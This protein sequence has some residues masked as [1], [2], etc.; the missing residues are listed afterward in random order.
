MNSLT[1]P[2]IADMLRPSAETIARELLPNGKR[3]GREWHCTGSNSPVGE[4]VGVVLSGAK[5]GTCCFF[6]SNRGG[7]LIELAQTVLGLDKRGAV[8][9]AKQFLGLP[10]DDRPIDPKEVERRRAAA[11]KQ[12]KQRERQEAR[13]NYRKIKSAWEIWDEAQ[14]LKLAYAY[15]KSRGID[16][17]HADGEI[18]GHPDLPHPQGSFPALVARVT[19]GEGKFAGIWRIYLAKYG[20]GK[21]PVD[22]P[23][24]GLGVVRGG[25]VR[26]GGT[27]NFIGIAEGIETALAVRQL[28]FEQTGN[29]I[30]VW[31][32]LSANGMQSVQIPE[33]V[34]RVRIY[35]DNDLARLD[36][37]RP[38]VGLTAAKALAERLEHEGVNVSI[39]EPPPG[40]DWLDRLNAMRAAA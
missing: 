30:P 37:G 38:S 33:S 26:I 19:D 3:Q 16:P 12:R 11:E 21:A 2:E 24:M 8:N 14:N 6:G 20:A 17:L 40:E 18:R 10:T 15:L 34:H 29:A 4:A 31:A 32:A 25:A 9:W 35:P 22:T 5:R 7:D 27:E 1:I 23:K 13:E 39:I 28:L 36:K